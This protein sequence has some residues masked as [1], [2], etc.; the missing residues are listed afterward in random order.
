[1]A[2]A[3]RGAAVLAGAWSRDGGDE[4]A[5]YLL[6]ADGTD[7]VVETDIAPLVVVPEGAVGM[8]LHGS[9]VGEHV[10]GWLLGLPRFGG[11]RGRVVLY[12]AD[13]GA[14][15]AVWTGESVGNLAGGGLTTADLN[16]DGMEDLVVGAWG[17]SG[18]SGAVQVSFAPFD[19]ET[20]LADADRMWVGDAF[21]LAGFSLAVGDVD[22]D[23]QD[24]VVVG[25]FGD[26]RNGSGAGALTV[27]PGASDSAPLLDF[28]AHRLGLVPD[29]HFGSALSV[30][31]VDL[32]GCADITVGAPDAS[33]GGVVQLHYG[34]IEGVGTTGDAMLVDPEVG[35][36][37][38]LGTAVGLDA[39]WG[40][41]AGAPD[42]E[43]GTGRVLFAAATPPPLP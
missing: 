8:I 12:D 19:G 11:D 18:F 37:A 10:G 17:Y 2:L 13:T 20:S 16:G 29:A 39:D 22:G 7:A 41:V 34:P 23:G 35:A 21:A 24:D 6:S 33:T 5:V 42:H 38:G 43:A 4:G 28:D 1:M 40:W 36:V 32:D 25:S 14:E 26:T 3:S 15:Q 31:D 30:A 27:V 9:G